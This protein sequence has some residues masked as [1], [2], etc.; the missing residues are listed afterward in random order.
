MNLNKKKRQPNIYTAPSTHRTA[1]MPSLPAATLTPFLIPSFLREL[2]GLL[3]PIP[4]RRPIHFYSWWDPVISQLLTPSSSTKGM[5]KWSKIE[6]SCW[7]NWT[8]ENWLSS[9]LGDS[10]ES[11]QNQ[12][13]PPQLP[14]SSF[15]LD[16]KKWKPHCPNYDLTSLAITRNMKM[17]SYCIACL[18]RIGG[19]SHS[20]SWLHQA[21]YLVIHTTS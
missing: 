21:K 1:N 11:S 2:G 3:S 14:L 10:P 17:L 8:P 5:Q 19:G 6:T 16:G 15:L 18:C 12:T 4:Q 9:S 13:S 7:S 20:F